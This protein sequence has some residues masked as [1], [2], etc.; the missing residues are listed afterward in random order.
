MSPATTKKRLDILVLERGLASSRHQAQGLILAGKVLVNDTPCDKPGAQIPLEARIRLKSGA[1][2]Q[3]VSRGGEKLAGA[4]TH[5][6]VSVRDSVVLDVGASTGGFSDCVLQAGARRVYA[7]DVGYNQLAHSLRN[8]P[9]VCVME[10][11]NAR[12]LQPEQFV[13][14]PDFV[15]MDVSF[16]GV[17]KIL[18]SVFAVCAESFRFLL[19]VKPQFELQPKDIAKGGVVRDERKGLLAVESVADFLRAQGLF[20]YGVQPSVLRGHKKGNQEYFLLGGSQSSA[21]FSD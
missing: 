16:I 20:V 19:L 21:R 5:F 10:K 15:T 2:L 12:T 4:L 17:E 18:P 14:P 8:D 11:V 7:V 9:R 6:G 1:A 13:E 3:Y